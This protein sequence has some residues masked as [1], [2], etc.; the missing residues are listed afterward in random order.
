LAAAR[1]AMADPHNG[2]IV[3]A[4]AMR[5]TNI[6]ELRNRLKQFPA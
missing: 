4:S 6:A 5:T 3:A 2:T 1:F